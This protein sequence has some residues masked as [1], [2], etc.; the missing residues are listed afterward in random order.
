MI[1]DPHIVSGVSTIRGRLNQ[2][3]K[4]YKNVTMGEWTGL[5]FAV[6]LPSLAILFVLDNLLHLPAWSRVVLW[7]GVASGIVYIVRR[8]GEAVR[9]GAT[10]EEMAVRVERAFPDLNNEL[11]NSLLLSKEAGEEAMQLVSAVVQSGTQDSGKLQLDRAVPKKKLR[12]LMGAAAAAGFIMVIYAA[13]FPDYFANAFQRVLLPVLSVEPLTLTRIREVA[14]GDANVL[15]GKTVKVEARFG[16]VLPKSAEV[17]YSVAGAEPQM[18][19]MGDDPNKPDVF[20]HDFRQV[21]HDTTYYVKARDA[22]SKAYKVKV[23]EQP[24]LRETRVELTYPEYCGLTKTT[25][26]KLKV[27]ALRGTTIDIY[28]EATKELKSASLTISGG[29]PVDIPVTDGLK[30]HAQIP[31]N[32]ALRYEIGL[33]DAFGF[34][35][36]PVPYA[37][38]VI[39]DNCPTI[40]VIEPAENLTVAEDT[41]IVFDFTVADDYGIRRI[42]LVQVDEKNG[43]ETLLQGWEFDVKFEKEHRRRYEL[44]ASELKLE[45]GK[46]NLKLRAEDWNDV[47]GPGIGEASFAIT[48]AARQ[49]VMK[50]AEEKAKKAE[51][52]LQEIITL[53]ERNLRETKV[54]LGSQGPFSVEADPLKTL[55]ARQEEIRKTTGELLAVLKGDAPVRAT[56]D[57]LFGV[58]MM[59]AIKQLR[60]V[61]QST[62][63]VERAIA[64]ESEILAR[65]TARKQSLAD[66]L[67]QKKMQDLFSELDAIIAAQKEL[68]TITEERTQGKPWNPKPIADRQDALSDRMAKFKVALKEHAA[69][70][71][72]SDNV[73]GTRF[74][75]A[76]AEIDSRQVREDMIKATAMIEREAATD[77]LP[78]QTRIIANLEAIKRMLRESIAERAEEK[79]K[80]LNELASKAAEKADKLVKLQQKVKQLSEEMEKAQDLSE[81]DNED[82]KAKLGEMDEMRK[83]MAEVIE[84]MAKDLNIF[85]EIPACNEMVQK[86]REVY[87]DIQQQEGSEATAVSEIAVKRDEGIL[88]ALEAL[89]ER[90]ADMEM[91]LKDTPDFIRWKNENFAKNEIPEIPLVDLPEELEDLVGD[92]VDQEEELDEEANDTASNAIFGDLPAGWNVDD[93]PMSSFGAKGK[94]G[95]EKPNTN[96]ATGRSGGGREGNANGEMVEGKAK[97]LEGRE[98][99]ERRTNDPFQKGEVE[100]ENPNSEAKATG[101]GKQSGAGGEGGLTGTAPPKNELGLRELERRQMEIRRNTEKIYSQS[102]LLFLPT[103]ELDAAVAMMQQAQFSL[104]QGDMP[105]FRSLQKQIVHALDN[106]RRE[107]RG[108]AKLQLDP[109]M[110]VPAEMKETIRD[111]S[112]ERIPAEYEGIVSEYYKALAERVTE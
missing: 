111:A 35:N 11:I 87:E 70:V 93:G 82:L 8:A 2:V 105:G 40:D 26:S 109:W 34:R 106:T 15:S 57:G 81:N 108:E 19:K 44:Q 33:E 112:G 99:K 52:T 59:L 95:N 23:H 62:K 84:K 60:E 64:T 16:G 32:D 65:L 36:D 66:T 29:K 71:S 37:A 96:E 27:K 61:A 100:E 72:R 94:S 14:P 88:A 89:K 107:L 92:L 13:A 42:T 51:A 79:L 39:T 3:R 47:S 63:N 22:K 98:T 28:A 83:K 58:E 43:Q 75:N 38:D 104:A 20:Y 49:V 68:R 78:V 48:V 69:E 73:L 5:A 74:D 30:L 86:M 76:A 90:I 54:I 102:V 18:M 12:I 101:G 21:T 91:W 55:V 41:K 50:K 25:Q 80:K 45:S 97:D 1:T 56:L 9:V 77:A 31:L 17:W 7:L 6:V 46:A 85:P 4:H 53:Q 10:D 67:N 24:A 103:G 110:K